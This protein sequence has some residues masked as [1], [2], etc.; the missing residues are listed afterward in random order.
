MAIK[1]ERSND[2]SLVTRMR[3]VSIWY[4]ARTARGVEE[5]TEFML[6]SALE[7]D[8]FRSSANVIGIYTVPDFRKSMGLE[9][10]GDSMEWQYMSDER[11]VSVMMERQLP[12]RKW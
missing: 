3:V 4:M 2:T 1:Y 8:D 5:R 9:W 6:V 12:P 7:L 11:W 10:P